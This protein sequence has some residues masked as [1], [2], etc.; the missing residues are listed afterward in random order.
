VAIVL[1]APQGLHRLGL[2]MQHP[3]LATGGAMNEKLANAAIINATKRSFFIFF[4]S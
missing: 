3:A 2:G 1:A 4:S